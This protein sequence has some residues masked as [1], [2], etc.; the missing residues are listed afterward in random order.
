VDELNKQFEGNSALPLAADFSVA[1]NE[2]IATATY[3]QIDILVNNLG[4][5]ALCDFFETSDE[6]WGGC[7]ISMSGAACD[8]LEPT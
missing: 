4:T 2:K 7:S 8:W 5:Y 3:P 1:G 6:D